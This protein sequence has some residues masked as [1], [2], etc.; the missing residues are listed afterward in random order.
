M[1]GYIP[2]LQEAFQDQLDQ[3]TDKLASLQGVT[4][5]PKEKKT[6]DQSCSPQTWASPPIILQRQEIQQQAKAMVNHLEQLQDIMDEIKQ[7]VT[8]HRSRPSPEQMATCEDDLR[9]I[10]GM[11]QDLSNLL[12]KE[13]PT[14]KQ[15]WELQ[16]QK[17]IQEQHDVEDWE[18][19]IIDAQDD[20]QTMR[21]IMDHLHQVVDLYRQQTSQ[22]GLQRCKGSRSFIF[23]SPTSATSQLRT[24]DVDHDRRIQA[25][26][27][28][29][30]KRSKWVTHRIDDF[31]KE[32]ISFVDCKQLKNV[33]GAAQLEQIQAE[34]RK[35]LLQDLYQA[36]K[37]ELI[38]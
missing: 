20:V 2:K 3:W 6:K 5:Q 35:K 25:L 7:D 8:H 28:A 27:K 30:Q 17:I 31:E 18:H 13:K 16:L 36:E 22:S 24:I 15:A 37:S 12:A 9:L 14:W 1:D 19:L 23:S 4:A 10:Q 38:Y 21:A 26:A 29:E 34:K 32:L 33:G 11:V